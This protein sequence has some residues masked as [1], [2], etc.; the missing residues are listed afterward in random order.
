MTNPSGFSS[1]SSETSK[2]PEINPVILLKGFGD[3]VE[4][5]SQHLLGLHLSDEKLNGEG[6]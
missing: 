2:A 4:Q 1:L 5:V 6:Y 3:T